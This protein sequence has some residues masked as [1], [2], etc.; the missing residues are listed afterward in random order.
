MAAEFGHAGL[1]DSFTRRLRR[2]SVRTMENHSA[3]ITSS[4]RRRVTH[5]T[6]QSVR[7]TH[8]LANRQFAFQIATRHL[9]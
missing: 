8:F 5:T 7:A 9:V 1:T 3:R 4:A 2:P 6:A